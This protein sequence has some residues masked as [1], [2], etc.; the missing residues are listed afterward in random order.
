M[1]TNTS[2]LAMHG[3]TCK[4]G[5]RW[6][7]RLLALIAVAVT[8]TAQPSDVEKAK[9]ISEVTRATTMFADRGHV[10][11]C[12]PNRSGPSKDCKE[13]TNLLDSGNQAAIQKSFARWKAQARKNSKARLLEDGTSLPVYSNPRAKLVYG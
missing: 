8:V 11:V 4:Y 9:Y 10:S 6:S 1:N 5:C 2:I 12:A 13:V 7:A 3:A